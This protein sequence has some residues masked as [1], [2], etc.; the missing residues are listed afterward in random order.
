MPKRRSL[1][2]T[3]REAIGDAGETRPDAP[4]A[5]TAPAVERAAK[6]PRAAPKSKA[7]VAPNPAPPARPQA[8]PTPEGQS[9]AV[10]SPGTAYEAM[11]GFASATL[12][13]NLETSAKLARCKSPVEALAAQTAHSAAIM[14]N[15]IAISLKLM[16]LGFSTAMWSPSRRFERHAPSP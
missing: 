4:F 14:Q 16:Q 8:E 13:Q 3:G 1:V 10:A 11:M 9:G 7:A 15:L 5:P 2:G 6:R 12:R